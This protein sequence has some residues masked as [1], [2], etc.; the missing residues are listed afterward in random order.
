M[1]SVKQN[2]SS[3]ENGKDR[4]LH[5]VLYIDGNSF[6]EWTVRKSKHGYGRAMGAPTNANL[7][8]EVYAYLKS[9]N[10]P[11]GANHHIV[12]SRGTLEHFSS[13]Y[14]KDQFTGEIVAR[15]KAPPFMVINS[16]GS[17]YTFSRDV[18][19][20]KDLEKKLAQQ[21]KEGTYTG[22]DFYP[23]KD[24]YGSDGRLKPKKPN[25]NS[26]ADH[27]NPVDADE[28]AARELY[29]YITNDG[30]LMR[31]Q[32][33][34][35]HKNLITK[36]ARGIYKTA[37]AVKLAMYLMDNGAKKY[38]KEFGGTWNNM[39][40]KATRE[41]AA[42]E[43]IEDFEGEAKYGSY[44]HYLPKKY[45]KNSVTENPPGAE[46]PVGQLPKGCIAVKDEYGRW[47]VT[48]PEL[49]GRN[50]I[51]LGDTKRE[52]ITDARSTIAHTK[53]GVVAF[54]KS[55]RNSTAS[56]EG[57]S[58]FNKKETAERYKIAVRQLKQYPF[59]LD[60][61]DEIRRY[62][63][64]LG[65]GHERILKDLSSARR[66]LVVLPKR[67]STATE[68]KQHQSN[69]LTELA[70]T[71]Q[72]KA[73]G[74]K[75]RVLQSEY[76]PKDKYRLGHLVELT[77]KDAGK[78]VKI[79]FDG[80]AYLAGD[81]RNNLYIVGKDSRLD[82]IKLPAQGRLQYLGELVQI[83]YVTAKEHI[84]AGKTVRFYHKLGEVTK[85]YPNLFVDHEGFLHIQGGAYDIWD[86]GI[87]N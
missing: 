71:F 55:K 79:E 61:Q 12:E 24:Q 20:I 65:L 57:Y 46:N 87:V 9:F 53:R 82:N 22:L 49:Y 38:A 18:K 60:I 25:S 10:D 76:T 19:R 59:S 17:S 72:G 52:A 23:S 37:L 50:I 26:V 34:P 77:L 6:G 80:E 11:K 67:N 64:A 31:Q 21:K 39:F 29:L 54:N 7:E 14:I 36:K 13:A 27:Q 75:V 85:E 2:I 33:E 69:K 73:N 51:G 70:Q 28:H 44:D 43:F 48:Y 1:Q 30:A 68:F 66:G 58:P 15:W 16:G 40:S 86:V 41:L 84:E 47:K 3:I 8:K 5:Y 63:S 42:K 35:I 56:N 45:Q 81:S 62:G 78:R 4:T 83:D 74:A 32:G